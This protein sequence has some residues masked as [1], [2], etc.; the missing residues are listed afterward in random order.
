LERGAS[1][2][3]ARLYHDLRHR[4]ERF[5]QFLGVALA[6]AIAFAGSPT[7]ALLLSGVLP[8]VAGVLIRMWASGHVKKDKELATDGPY[9]FVR[10]P[11]YVGNILILLAFCLASGSWWAWVAAA[12]LLAAFYPP[13]ISQEDG[14]LRRLFGENWELWRA[15]V[16]ALLPRLTPFQPG[17]SAQW[18]FGQSLMR[19]GE[20]I[21][22]AFLSILMFVMYMKLD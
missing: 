3:L 9:A 1:A 4:R 10:H 21:I 6:I 16:R 17:R 11:L 14:K 2:G 15:E 8:F 19:N 5:R 22:A 7:R 12:L 13:A 20:P 18:S